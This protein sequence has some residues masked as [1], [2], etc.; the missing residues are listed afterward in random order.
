MSDCQKNKNPLVRGG[1]NRNERILPALEKGFVL[2]DERR[3][4]D[5]IVYTRNLAAKIKYINAKNDPEGNWQTFFDA[6]ISSKLALV[7]V[8]DIND[9]KER[10]RSLF[11]AIQ[12][13][14]AQANPVKLKQD[15]GLLYGAVLSLAQ[16]M[17]HFMRVLPDEAPL[18]RTLANL[19]AGKL[20]PALKR[21]LGYYKGAK[22]YSPASVLLFEVPADK[23]TILAYPQ[24]RAA[25]VISDGLSEKW[26]GDAPDWNAYYSALPADLSIYNRKNDTPV[27][28]AEVWPMLSH[29]ASHNLFSSVFAEFLSAY[30]RIVRD[31]QQQ[32]AGSIAD[33][34][35]HEP[36]YALYLTFLHLLRHAQ[37]QMNGYTGKHLDFY[38]R[39]IL[40]LRPRPGEPDHVHLAFETARGVNDFLLA[41][42]TGFKAGKGSDG[43]EILYL[44]D[45]DT[46]L[47]RA[48]VTDLRSFYRAGETDR[49]KDGPLRFKGLLYASPVA[50]SA[51]G[52]GAKLITESGDWP[53]FANKIFKDGSLEAIRM[54]ETRVG[55]ALASP[56]LFLKEGRRTLTVK[57]K[58]TGLKP[59]DGKT[60]DVYLTGEKGWT[61]KTDI[62]CSATA[63][64]ATFTVVVEPGDPP[65]TAFVPNIHGDGFAPADT[66]LAKFLLRNIAGTDRY[67]ELKNL[68][69]DHAEITVN[70][71]TLAGQFNTDGIKELAVY[72]DSGAADPSKPFIPFGQNPKRGAGLVIG[73]RELFG[74]TGAKFK[75][76]IEWADLIDRIQDMDLNLTD[77]FFP[78]A[79]LQFLQNGVWTDGDFK[80]LLN[81]ENKVQDKGEVE[82]FWGAGSVMMAQTYLPSSP[83]PVPDEAVSDYRTE[84][85]PFGIDS[86]NGFLKLR[87]N[88]DFQWDQYYAALQSYYIRLANKTLEAGETLPVKPYLPKIQSM[89]LSYEAT[90]TIDFSAA[91][92]RSR[93]IHLYPFG[94]EVVSGEADGKVFLLPQFTHRAEGLTQP[95][96]AEFYI[97]L[98]QAA[99]PQK[100]N[101]LFNV[102]DGSTDPLQAK[103]ERHVHWSY[104]KGNRWIDF[105][106][107]EIN[108]A[109]KQLIE[110]GIVSFALPEAADTEHTVLPAGKHWL[111]AGIQTLPEQVCRLIDVRAQ[112]IRATLDK[113]GRAENFSQ[114]PL[115]AGSISK[116]L[117]PEPALKKTEQPYATFGGR[118]PETERQF[119][120]RVSE[121]LRH[122]NRA[123]SIRDIEQLV[124]EK[125]P[126]IHKVK[127]LN[128]TRL[129]LD[130]PVV[131]NE[132]AP[133]HVTVITVPDLR[134]R[135]AI[136]PLRPYTGRSRLLDIKAFLE[137]LANCNMRW[138]V[139]N[140]SFEEIRIKTDI[141]LTADAAGNDVFYA[142]LLRDDLL[143]FLTPWAHDPGTDIRFGGKI[144]QST[145]INFIEER[146]YVDTILNLQMFHRPENGPESG[147][148]DEITASTARSVLVSA[149]AAKHE[150]SILPR[151]AKTDYRECE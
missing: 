119:Y 80:S 9:Y 20:A 118:Y 101:I 3:F 92:N 131:Y 148:L 139:E 138:H 107:N 35:T 141:V 4:A 23:W 70:V 67:D 30:A 140:P 49:Q 55:F 82:L 24:E 136:N 137:S 112:V 57:L 124:L 66:P 45:A 90:D 85:A 78:S 17:D 150:I 108:D 25:E 28:D 16:G 15:F 48:A 116:P 91:G 10:I 63:S 105:D 64:T 125:F 73:N 59:L 132:L 103:P 32:L 60:F 27:T 120:T 40:R 146:P 61:E 83:L 37:D 144:T 13:K 38:Y 29:A 68:R 50:N 46:V 65:V 47:N 143:K 97:G 39:E 115:P 36:H 72:T 41:K 2:P 8:Q 75:L 134:N 12:A 84:N 121:R 95:H 113:R 88:A 53:A 1:T 147:N 123:I 99:P 102:L 69:I 44:A 33:L 122:K 31:A 94:T 6:D 71:G 151:P 18:K 111:R 43:K 129:E 26:Y 135:N 56:H 34:D 51:D 86:R 79:Q 87:L 54:P 128:H 52:L 74:K 127:C 114:K 76:F 58:G 149:P 106:Q 81:K 142:N 11:G 145:L 98:E 96:V 100:I 42:D 21:L 109:S 77:N 126:D 62:G 104:L 89:Y 117:L 14:E 7:A 93:F 133:G 130:T 110:T 19:T 5:W 22:A